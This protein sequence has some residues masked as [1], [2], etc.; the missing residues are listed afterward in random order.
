MRNDMPTEN[1]VKNEPAGGGLGG[2][3]A[4]L[5]KAFLLAAMA[6]PTAAFTGSAAADA[7]WY[8]TGG[9]QPSGP[10]RWYHTGNSTPARSSR[11]P[12][13]SVSR[14]R[15]AV[16]PRHWPA[17]PATGSANPPPAA[18]PL[19]VLDKPIFQPQPAGGL[20]ISTGPAIGGR[21][22]VAGAVKYRIVLPP[23]SRGGAIVLAPARLGGQR[24]TVAEDQ[25]IRATARTGVVVSW[26]GQARA[27]AAAR[28]MRAATVW[29]GPKGELRVSATAQITGENR[30]AVRGRAALEGVAV[31]VKLRD[32]QMERIQFLTHAPAT[33]AVLLTQYTPADLPLRIPAKFIRRGKAPATL[34]LAV[35]SSR[36][37]DGWWVYL[38]RGG[39]MVVVW[40]SNESEYPTFQSGVLFWL[41]A[42]VLA[43]DYASSAGWQD[44]YGADDVGA[45]NVRRE[46]TLAVQA[47]VKMLR[48]LRS[49][50]LRVELYAGGPVLEKVVYAR[51]L[52]VTPAATQ[53]A[54]RPVGNSPAR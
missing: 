32:G 38:A 46:K 5:A 40:D 24:Q 54:R 29:V 34:R 41:K 14:A 36:A 50:T 21:I 13:P 20:S 51:R 3:R 26:V 1:G 8:N 39:N 47:R 6:L 49:I 35:D 37:Q 25:W 9:S 27:G 53:R 2:P 45:G 31:D 28:A 42:L 43:N 33:K 52:P 15:P 7:R 44:N 18:Q 23:K 19:L 16:R 48:P 12:T 30:T 11:S 17:P 10:A 4:L 22:S